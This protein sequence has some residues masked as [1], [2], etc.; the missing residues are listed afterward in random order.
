VDLFRRYGS[1]VRSIVEIIQTPTTEQQYLTDIR[2]GASNFAND[3]QEAFSN[4][5][6]LDF[7]SDASSKIFTV[8]PHGVSR[9]P[10]LKIPTPFLATMLGL[11]LARVAVARQQAAFTMLSKHPSLRTA[12][13]WLFENYGHAVLSDPNRAP[14]ATYIR[15]EIEAPS[16]PPP[17]NVISGSTALKNIRPPFSFYWRLRETN[18]EGLDAIIRHN[19]TVWGLQYTIRAKHG[20]VLEGLNQVRKEMNHK[21][22]VK[23][24]V[25]MLGSER[26]DAESARDNQKLTGAWA[27]TPI[28]ACVLPLGTV[29]EALLRNV[30][31]EVSI[32]DDL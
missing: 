17:N 1:N 10:V 18:F 22:G 25:A 24:R 6:N 29:N 31:D 11:A 27:K 30:L 9:E 20:S 3:F 12:A 26:A 14:L 13:G 32:S 15:D 16:I 23:Y 21:R 5:Q 7:G 19:N 2:S 8:R 28:S 4:L